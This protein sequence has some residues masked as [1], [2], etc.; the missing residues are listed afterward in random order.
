MAAQ[1]LVEQGHC[2]AKAVL[3]GRNSL[4]DTELLAKPPEGPI[5]ERNGGSAIGPTSLSAPD[6]KKILTAYV[7]KISWM[8]LLL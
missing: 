1:L 7:M 3:P 8:Q 5:L 2:A 6:V 4:Q